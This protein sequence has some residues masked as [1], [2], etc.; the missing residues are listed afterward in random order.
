MF[1]LFILL[2]S[3]YFCTARTTLSIN[4]DMVSVVG[5]GVDLLTESSLSVIEN[6]QTSKLMVSLN[7]HF[8]SAFSVMHADLCVFVCPGLISVSLLSRMCLP[9]VFSCE[10]FPVNY[11]YP[12]R[13]KRNRDIVQR[14]DL[15]FVYAYLR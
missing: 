8:T 14:H 5:S 2:L 11:D 6:K 10:L 1:H 7:I 13:I 12:A 4:A 15:M 9:L 3:M